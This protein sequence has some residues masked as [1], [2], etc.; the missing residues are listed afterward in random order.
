MYHAPR[1]SRVVTGVLLAIVLFGT[2]AEVSAQSRTP[3]D[4]ARAHFRL[5]RTHYENGDFEKAAVEF[6]EAYRLSPEPLLLYNL[7]VAYRDA[8][9]LRAAAT[10]LR[11]YL[12]L[13]PEIANRPQLEA[14][15]EAL[16]KGLADEDARR[17]SDP[18]GE[19]EP[20][21]QGEAPR[22]PD[23]APAT[24]TAAPTRATRRPIAP[25]VVIGVGA[26]VGASAIATGLL[27]R[28]AQSELERGCPDRTQC[29]PSLES[30]R[31]RGRTFALLTDVLAATGLVT[32]AAGV[33]WWL[34][35]RKRARQEEGALRSV[36][37]AC[38]REGCVGS[39]GM[40]F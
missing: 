31:D 9:E 6:E 12:D 32:V 21:N 34:L 15:L 11:K 25:F 40:R 4:R 13:A 28:S 10:A 22:G 33:T 17:A 35:A 3:E 26:A 38:V 23:G 29:D 20:E 30:T 14:R 18:S 8:N 1:M 37:L 39:V 7:Y 27:A 5:G 36:G 24:D 2:G 19:T 16:E